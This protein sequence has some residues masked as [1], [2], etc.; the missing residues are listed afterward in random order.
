MFGLE[1][2]GDPLSNPRPPSLSFRICSIS[3]LLLSTQSL[4][5]DS[6]N[7]QLTNPISRFSPCRLETDVHQGVSEADVAKRR[8]MFGYNEL[9]SPSENLILKFFTFFKGPILYGE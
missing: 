4:E 8:S 1:G 3:T 9:E 6:K 7:S 5:F 2:V